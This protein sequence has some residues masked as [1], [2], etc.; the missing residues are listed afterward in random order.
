[1]SFEQER[2]S[3]QKLELILVDHYAHSRGLYSL[4]LA[5]ELV[6]LVVGIIGGRLN[7]FDVYRL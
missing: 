1:M 2:L 6:G 3:F 4:P 5:M 7:D